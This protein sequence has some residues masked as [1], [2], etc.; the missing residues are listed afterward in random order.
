MSRSAGPQKTTVTLQV[1]VEL[2]R[3]CNTSVED[4]SSGTIA[5]SVGIVQGIHSDMMALYDDKESYGWP[6]VEFLTCRYCETMYK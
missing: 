1:P 4:G 6:D 3:V 5:A 2:Y